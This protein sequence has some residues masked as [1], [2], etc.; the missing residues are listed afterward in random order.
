MA[1]IVI[2]PGAPVPIL[3]HCDGNS[4]R[5]QN[6]NTQNQLSVTVHKKHFSVFYNESRYR[7]IAGNP[8][9]RSRNI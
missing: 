6:Q 8:N 3:V 4:H 1:F 9:G 2:F 5:Q 7:F